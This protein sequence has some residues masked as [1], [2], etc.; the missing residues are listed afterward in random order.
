MRR[1]ASLTLAGLLAAACG[2][3]AATGVA[4]ASVAGIEVAQSTST[5]PVLIECPIDS[6]LSLAGSIDPLLGGSLS[7]DGTTVTIPGGA[8]LLPTEIVLTIPA[9]RY[10]EIDISVPGT[11]HF[12]F[13]KPIAVSV[14]YA[15]CSRSN[16]N[17]VALSIWYIDSATK[18]LLANMHGTDYKEERRID[19][20]T[21]HLSG[22]ALAN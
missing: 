12:E 19:F 14:S 10:M 7:L 18:A 4:G 13:Q 15:R 3:P 8:V 1:I 16:I 6:T 2:D 9:S 21:D 5:G 22:Y 11:E 17:K 20:K